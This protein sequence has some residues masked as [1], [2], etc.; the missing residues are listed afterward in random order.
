MRKILFSAAASGALLPLMMNTAFAQDAASETAANPLTSTAGCSGS[1]IVLMVLLF[2]AMW[3]FMIRPQRKKEKEAKSMQDSVQV[4]DEIVTIGGIVGLCVKTGDDNIVIETG[5]DRHKIRI[6]KWAIQENL[7]VS[8][9][10]QKEN[11]QKA[12]EKKSLFGRKNKDG[13]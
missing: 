9:R 8:E 4:G 2:A 13:E 5:G 1:Y 12:A 10:I 11:V 6:K 7:T 3:F